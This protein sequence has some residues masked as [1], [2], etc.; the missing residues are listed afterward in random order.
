MNQWFL[1]LLMAGLMLIGAEVFIP[2]GVLGVVGAMALVTAAVIGFSIFPPAVA[3]LVAVGMIGMVGVVIVLWIRIF[4]HTGIGRQMTV[5]RDLKD[6][7]GTD[8]GMG[9]LLGKT[10]VTRSALRPSGF[11][12]VDNRRLD[13]VTAG[14]MIDRDVPV[15]IVAVQ[16]NRVVVE[17]V[18][19][20]DAAPQG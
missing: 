15:R 5:F 13:V 8:A 12:E 9:G 16:G 10:G 6:A 17:A 18:Q 1:M 20:P 3:A 4:P 14:E 11:I 7:K 19:P 2:G